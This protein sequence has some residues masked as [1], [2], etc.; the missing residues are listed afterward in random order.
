MAVGGSVEIVLKMDGLST[1]LKGLEETDKGFEKATTSAKKMI[2]ELEKSSDQL[3][4]AGDAF[5]DVGGTMLAGLALPMAGIKKA[6]SMF[7]D[8]EYGFAKAGTLMSPEM[9]MD[10]FTKSVLDQ[11]R[12]TGVDASHLIGETIYEALSSDVAE[13][14]V[15]DLS[16]IAHKLSTAGFTDS[17]TAMLSL[18]HI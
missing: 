14:D 13:E 17:A 8:L 1:V 10:A 4:Q 18:I 3:K 12:A 16:M 11:A 15:L 2:K 5:K 6:G 9:D 7:S